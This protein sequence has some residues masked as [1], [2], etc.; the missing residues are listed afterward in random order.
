[1]KRWQWGTK[2]TDFFFTSSKKGQN[3][4]FSACF[5]V[6]IFMEI[7]VSFMLGPSERHGVL[8]GEME[9]RETSVDRRAVECTDA[10]FTSVV[11]EWQPLTVDRCFKNNQPWLNQFFTWVWCICVTCIPKNWPNRHTHNSRKSTLMAVSE[12]HQSKR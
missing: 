11:L 12:F 6:R 3:L 2:T 10:I 9:G 5:I 1:M 8:Y 4:L 7:I